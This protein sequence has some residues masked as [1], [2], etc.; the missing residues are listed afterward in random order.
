M[1]ALLS[2]SSHSGTHGARAPVAPLRARRHDACARRRRPYPGVD[3]RLSPV[4]LQVLMALL[5]G[6]SLTAQAGDYFDPALLNLGGGQQVDL[7][8][9]ERPGGQAEGTYSVDIYANNEFMGT[10][11]VKFVHDS[12]GNLQPVIT[13][14][15]LDGWGVNLKSRDDL[16][17]LPVKEALTQPLTTYIPQASMKLDFSQMR[18]MVNIPQLYMKPNRD[19]LADPSLWQDGDTAFLLNYNLSGSTYESKNDGNRNNNQG[20]FASL[21]PGI[22]VGPWRIRNSSTYSYNQQRFDR[23]DALQNEKNRMVQTQT[24]W[25]SLQ[26]YVQRDIDVLR[27]QLTIGETSTGSVASQVLDGFSFRGVGLMSSD[28]MIPGSM[29]GFAPVVTG[30]ARSNARVTVTQNGYTIYQANVAPGPFRFD[31]LS[32]SGTGGDLEVSVTESDGSVHGYRLP[33]SSLPVMQRQGQ[34]RYEAAAGE[35]YTGHGG[36][37]ATGTP[38]FGMLTAIYGLTSGVTLYGG[39]IGAN[40]YQS[41]ALGAGFSI[42]DYGAVSLDATHSRATLS[43]SEDT[44]SGESYRA[45]YSKSMMASGTTVDLTAYRYST[46]NYLSFNDANNRGFDTTTGLPDW[47]NDRRRNSYEARLSQTLFEDYQL[48]LQGHRD[49]YWGSDKTNTTMSAGISGSVKKVGWSLN[50]SIDRMRGDGDWPENRQWTLNLNVPMSLFGSAAALQN[51][52]ASYTFSND[53]TGRST[54]ML[55]MGGSL[56]DDNSMNWSASQTQGNGDQGNSGSTSLG[57]NDTWG[58]AN[59]GYNYDHGGGHGVTYSASGGVLAHRHGV[60]LARN[61]NDAAVLVHTGVPDVKI[62]NGSATTDHWGNAVVTSM[63]TYSRNTIDIDP[64]S[65]PEG[66]NPPSGGHALYPTAGAVLVEDYPVRLGQQ[67]LMNL[68]HNGSPV[69]FGAMASLKGDDADGQ[70]SIVGDGGQVYLGG[71]P[72]KGTLLVKWGTTSDAQCEVPFTLDKP[73]PRRKGDKSWR[74]VK[75]VNMT[76]R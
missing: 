42:L 28:A 32:G 49:N 75:T 34:L 55:T 69:P 65:L 3:R 68:S 47:L 76:C 11:S 48:W 16:S 13:P 59:L 17:A 21:Q 5:G 74:P 54:N 20:F 52:Y 30:I 35:Y 26:T 23:Y 72:E 45:R 51:G 4:C 6:G 53:N 29:N 36:Y 46:R 56:L 62:M 12:E 73:E 39:G 67:I 70:S 33:Y 15:D 57:Y 24:Q 37:D 22:N 14:S 2:T 7:S 19:T 43:G 27:S 50:Y 9:F 61:I 71:M 58:M 31:D 60:T 40:G 63:Q 66:A 64:S 8:Q 44:L 18:L 10:H 41:A 38:G 1:K 25:T